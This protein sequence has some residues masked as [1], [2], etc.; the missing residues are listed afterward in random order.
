MHGAIAKVVN[1][2]YVI[3]VVPKAPPAIISPPL[4]RDNG[5]S[6]EILFKVC[7]YVYTCTYNQLLVKLFDMQN[8]IMVHCTCGTKWFSV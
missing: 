5:N 6:I 8:T 2:V 1:V 4:R 7:N 3:L